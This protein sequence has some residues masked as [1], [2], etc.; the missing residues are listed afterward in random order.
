MIQSAVTI[1]L[2][3]EAA[4][5]PFVFWHDLPGAIAEARSLGFDAVEVF[6]PAP[7]AVDPRQ[8]QR[9]L[10][11]QGLKLAAVGTGGGWVRQ[12]LHLC[13]PDAGGRQRARD[14]IR[15]IID[16]AGGLGAPAIIGSMQGRWGEGVSREQAR[17]WLVEA[18][19]ELGAHANSY[20]VP[21]LYEPLNRYETNLVNTVEQGLELLRPLPA[22]R[23]KLLCDLFHMNIEEVDI[24]ASLMAAGS[25]LGHL[26][27][28]DS[29]RRPA[30][31]GHLDYGPIAR[32]LKSLD[33]GGYASA[34]AFAWPDSST[35][36][37][38]TSDMFRRLFR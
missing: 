15:G 22:G 5:G 38:Q 10:D 34:E 17:D 21:L 23:V 8:L 7:D 6:P 30:G 19:A 2:V 12:K 37:R 4:G 24:A 1:S 20:G 16:L 35:A 26:H 14:S 36:A 25:Q 11:D 33:Y 18:L 31:Y 13:L 32:A 28:V 3:A 29:N 9:L 27:F